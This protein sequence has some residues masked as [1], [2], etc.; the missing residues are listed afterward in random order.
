MTWRMTWAQEVNVA[1]N[2]AALINFASTLFFCAAIALLSFL[3]CY[4][5]RRGVIAE[6]EDSCSLLKV[7]VVAGRFYC[8]ACG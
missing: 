2:V 1:A 4:C 6:G 5:W 7:V 8:P 3:C